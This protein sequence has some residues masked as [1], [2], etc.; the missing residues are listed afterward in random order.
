[1]LVFKRFAETGRATTGDDVTQFEG[2][3]SSFKAGL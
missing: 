3:E 2:L 1:M